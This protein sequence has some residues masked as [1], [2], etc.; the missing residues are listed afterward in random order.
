MNKTQL[1]AL[2]REKKRQLTPSQITDCSVR[3]A[4]KLFSHPAYKNA[5]TIYGYL[6]YNQEVRTMPVLQQAQR[7]GKRVAVPKVFGEEMRFLWL[8]DLTA[9]AEGAYGIPEPIADDPAADDETA[10]VL[11]PGLAFDA[12]GHR[13]GYGGGFY[14]KYLQAHPQHPTLALCYDFQMFE[15]LD[16]DAHDIPVQF[17]L[18]EPVGGE[19]R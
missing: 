11:M 7:D 8:D 5:R 13:C 4:Q 6:S 10:L 2:V 14:D 12:Q 18:S 17:V 16:T 19:N 9:V 1:R 3:L 15:H